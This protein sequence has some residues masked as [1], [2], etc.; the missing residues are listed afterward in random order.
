MEAFANFF[1]VNV[2]N[3]FANLP[4]PASFKD[5][6]NLSGRDVL[7]LVPFFTSIGLAGYIT[8]K[9]IN[10][11]LN[12]HESSWVNKDYCKNKNKIADIISQGE[13]NTAI[14]KNDKVAYCRCWKSKTVKKIIINSFKFEINFII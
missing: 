13:I 14:E 1:K 7:S 9:E 2:S 12:R 4:L 6:S 3:Y 11:Y 10:D 5:V 8:Y